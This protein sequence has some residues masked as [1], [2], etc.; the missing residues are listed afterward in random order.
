MYVI[1]FPDEEERK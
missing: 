1:R